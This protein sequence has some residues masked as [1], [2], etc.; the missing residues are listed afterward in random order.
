MRTLI[1]LGAL[2]AAAAVAVLVL[3]SG[4]TIARRPPQRS[5]LLRPQIGLNNISG[6]ECVDV[7]GSRVLLLRG[8]AVSSPAQSSSSKIDVLYVKFLSVPVAQ[9]VR[10][11]VESCA[12]GVTVELSLNAEP[13]EI[14]YTRCMVSST[15]LTVMFHRMGGYHMYHSM[16]IPTG[17]VQMYI[18]QAVVGRALK[19]ERLLKND[20]EL[21]VSFATLSENSRQGDFAWPAVAFHTALFGNGTARPLRDAAGGRPCFTGE[22]LAVGLGGE[23]AVVGKNLTAAVPTPDV[24]EHVQRMSKKL[25]DELSRWFPFAS[26][27]HP[28]L[29]IVRGVLYQKRA[30]IVVGTFGLRRNRGIDASLEQRLL[31]AIVAASTNEVPSAQQLS[32]SLGFPEFEHLNLAMQFAAVRQARWVLTSE[33]AGLV[34]MM[35]SPPGTTWVCV[36]DHHRNHAFEQSLANFHI[37]LARAVGVRLVVFEVSAGKEASLDRLNQLLSTPFVAGAVEI[38]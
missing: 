3:T 1:C 36:Y 23:F 37:G 9:N 34:W 10:Q 32:V 11:V 21:S 4:S 28:G 25:V 18:T 13:S 2:I 6:A 15:A 17:A 31:S 26:Q 12:T 24:V 30:R 7:M 19:Q 5:P 14:D 38:I 33:G 27:H 8:A 29:P 20:D 35:L 22:F 16:V